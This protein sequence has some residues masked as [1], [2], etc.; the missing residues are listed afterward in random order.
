MSRFGEVRLDWG[1]EPEQAFR[2][3]IGQIG[4]LHEK[5]DAGPL[6]IA[7]CCMVSLAALAAHKAR[8]FVGL[9]RIGLDRTA[10][11]PMVREVMLQGLLG[12]GMEMQDA[13]K[14]VREFVD[15]RPL[16]ENLVA[17]YEVCM[18]SVVGVEDEKAMGEPQAAS[19]ASPTS[20]A[21]STAS[22][23]TASTQ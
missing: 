19:E 5:V 9:S 15:E 6:Y 21:A 11:L 1:G 13:T 22:E 12:A 10:E 14:R 20:P 23:K 17:A 18:A 3:G 7:S 16:T 4:K 8:D 2:L